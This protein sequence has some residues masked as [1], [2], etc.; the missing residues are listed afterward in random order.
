MND[1]WEEKGALVSCTCERFLTM[2][3][4]LLLKLFDISA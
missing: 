3:L 2:F 1:N 4:L